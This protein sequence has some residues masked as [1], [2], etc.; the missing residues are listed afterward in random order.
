MYIYRLIRAIRVNQGKMPRGFPGGTI[1]ERRLRPERPPYYQRNC[2]QTV[3]RQ[4]RCRTISTL[5]RLLRVLNE[6]VTAAKPQPGTSVSDRSRFV[7]QSP[8]SR[9]RF[10]RSHT[11]YNYVRTQSTHHMETKRPRLSQ[12]QIFPRTHLDLRW[13]RHRSCVLFA[14]GSSSALFKCKRGRSGRSFCRI[15]LQLPHA[16]LCLVGKSRRFHRGLL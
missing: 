10:V 15:D 14:L 8:F 9:L 1:P 5:L 16:D 13:G 11:T 6:P 12:R 4:Q 7:S 3:R 2:D